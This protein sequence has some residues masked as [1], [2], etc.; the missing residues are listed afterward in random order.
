[1]WTALQVA[2]KHT[3]PIPIQDYAFRSAPWAKIHTETIPPGN[4]W[5]S[6]LPPMPL[7]Q[8]TQQCAASK[9][10]HNTHNTTLRFTAEDAC[11]IVYLPTTHS[12]VLFPAITQGNVCKPAHQLLTTSLIIPLEDASIIAQDILLPLPIILLED[13]SASVLLFLIYTEM[14]LLWDVWLNARGIRKLLLI[15]TRDY[16]LKYVPTTPCLLFTPRIPLWDVCQV[17]IHLFSLS[18]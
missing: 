18:Q 7:F 10:A 12:Q 5:F 16:A 17:N 11:I 13:V 14:N 6:A 15:I 3:L 4:V 1:M 9:Y 2:M 8:I